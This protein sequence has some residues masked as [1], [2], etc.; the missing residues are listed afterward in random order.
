[1]ISAAST[2][3]A[4][5]REAPPSQQPILR[6]LRT[7]IRTAAPAAKELMKYGHPH[8]NL[9]GSLFALAAQKH[10]VALYVAETDVVARHREQLKGLSIGR[11]CI[12]LRP[13]ATPDYT[14]LAR[15]L[16]EA[17]RAREAVASLRRPLKSK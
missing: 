12:R 9:F 11:S 10:H 6:R 13:A 16:K 3:S 2:V 5:M 14:E 7:L 1:M 8:Y 17:V 15:V 4:Y